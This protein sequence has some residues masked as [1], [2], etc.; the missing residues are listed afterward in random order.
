MQKNLNQ[1]DIAESECIQA[2]VSKVVIQAV[3]EVIMVLRDKDVG[4]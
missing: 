4:P 1:A 2:V 3:T